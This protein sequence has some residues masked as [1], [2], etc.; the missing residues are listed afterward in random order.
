[1]QLGVLSGDCPVFYKSSSIFS[2]SQ[3]HILRTVFRERTFAFAVELD[4]CLLGAVLPRCFALLCWCFALLCC[5]LLQEVICKRF[6]C[7]RAR[8]T[9]NLLERVVLL[10]WLCSVHVLVMFRLC[11]CF[12]VWLC[13]PEICLKK[14]LSYQVL[15]FWFVFSVLGFFIVVVCVPFASNAAGR[16]ATGAAPRIVLCSGWSP[17]SPA[18]PFVA[19]T[20]SV[21]VCVCVCVHACARARMRACL[22]A[23]LWGFVCGCACCCVRACA[24]ACVSACL[25]VW[26]HVFCLCTCGSV[27]ACAH[28]V[29]LRAR[30]WFILTSGGGWL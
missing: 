28:V 18:S 10:W 7:L 29:S 11:F 9:N 30:C 27:G 20:C 2:F 5:F 24:R 3:G 19:S 21:C 12:I 25:C 15:V 4:C 6:I 14:L 16:P 8:F 13:S 22:R 1:M 26:A 23:C 17:L